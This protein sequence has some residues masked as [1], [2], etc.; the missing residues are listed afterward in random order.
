MCRSQRLACNVC[1]PARVVSVPGGVDTRSA[2]TWGTQALRCVFVSTSLGVGGQ[3]EGRGVVSEM[4]S[5]LHGL[6]LLLFSLSWQ[7]T[8]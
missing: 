6:G 1:W 5:W 2:G 8:D 3:T 7:T 4:G